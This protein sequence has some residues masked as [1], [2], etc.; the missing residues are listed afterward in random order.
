M[1]TQQQNKGKN[2][3]IFLSSTF[4]DMDAER[5]AIMNSVY[6]A[7]AQQLAPH[8]I[9]VDFIDLRWGVST[10]DVDEAERENHVLRECID[11][12]QSSRPFFIGLL[13][14]R[15]GWVPSQESWDT[16]VDGMTEEEKRF[17]NSDT[18]QARS[19]TELEIL[20][21]SLMDTDNLHRSFFCFRSPEVYAH[22]DAAHLATF[23]EQGDAAARR[24]AQLKEKIAATMHAHRLD[25]NVCRYD[26]R[27]DGQHLTGMDTLAEFLTTA[28]VQEIMLY[29]CEDQT[30]NPDNAYEDM[31]RRDMERVAQ[32]NRLFCGRGDW[33]RWLKEYVATGGGKTLLLTAP[34]GFGKTALVCRLYELLENDGGFTPYIYFA[35]R[36]DGNCRP[37]MP[38]KCWLADPR[39]R[40]DHRCAPDADEDFGLLGHLLAK[41]FATD[42]KRKVLIVDD[43]TLL[44]EFQTLLDG[45]WVPDDTTVV[46]TS[47]SSLADGLTLCD[48][49]R[50]T[51]LSSDDARQLVDRRLAEVGKRLQPGV[52]EALLGKTEGKIHSAT[53]PLWAVMTARRLTLLNASYFDA[54]RQR[55]ESDDELKIQ[56]SLIEIIN[57]SEGYP[58][59][60]FMTIVKEGKQFVDMEFGLD[61]LRLLAVSEFGLRERDLRR[62][63][64]KEW[65]TLKFAELRRYLGSLLSEHEESGVIDFAWPNF[66]PELCIEA[67]GDIGRYLVA[68]AD[69]LRRVA[70]DD[71]LDPVA[72]RELP[73]LALKCQSTELLDLVVM[74]RGLMFHRSTIHALADLAVRRWQF[75]EKWLAKAVERRPAD[76]MR[77][78]PAV[79]ERLSDC[80]NYSSAAAIGSTIIRAVNANV[81]VGGDDT[82]LHRDFGCFTAFF[83]VCLYRAGDRQTAGQWA[84]WLLNEYVG[85]IGDDAYMEVFA[86]AV[87]VAASVW[88]DTGADAHGGD[89]GGDDGGNGDA[90]RQWTAHGLAFMQRLIIDGQRLEFLGAQHELADIFRTM[91]PQ[92]GGGSDTPTLLLFDD[93]L[94]ERPWVYRAYFKAAPLLRLADTMAETD[95]FVAD[96]LRAEAEH[97]MGLVTE[98]A[99]D[100]LL[101]QDP[102]RNGDNGSVG[103]STEEGT[104]ADGAIA[105]GTDETSVR[106]NLRVFQKALATADSRSTDVKR[107]VAN[108]IT[109]YANKVMGAYP[110]TDDSA[111]LRAMD[112]FMWLFISVMTRCGG[113]R[114][115]RLAELASCVF[116]TEYRLFM[117]QGERPSAEQTARLQVAFYMVCS[118]TEYAFRETVNAGADNGDSNL[119]ERVL[120][121]LR[122][123]KSLNLAD[124]LTVQGYALVYH[125]LAY[126]CEQRHDMKGMMFY[127]K[128]HEYATCEAWRLN[129]TDFEA[130]RRHAAAVDETGRMFY[131][132]CGNMKEAKLCFTKANTMF[133]ELYGRRKDGTI[134]NDIVLSSY[135]IINIL[136]SEGR[137]DELCAK[138]E[139][140]LALADGQ[141]GNPELD[142]AIVAAVSES[143]GHALVKLGR[144]GE[145]ERWLDEARDVYTENLRRNPDDEKRM[146]DLAIC[147][148]RQVEHRL[149]KGCNA[150]EALALVDK[151]E[152]L[153]K[154]ALEIVPDSP[155]VARNYIGVLNTKMRIHLFMR[156]F[157][158]TET[159]LTLFEQLTLEHIVATRDTSLMPLMFSCYDTFVD[160][161]AQAGWTQMANALLQVR[162]NAADRLVE[163]RLMKAE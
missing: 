159:A 49:A 163:E 53:T 63:L 97:L 141:C 91:H 13:G 136:N 46:C 161:A 106:A 145:A 41:A 151:A 66:R 6:P 9:T 78:M 19:V 158:N 34:Y 29:E 39:T 79:M 62:L 65:D 118:M 17:I 133:E 21:G 5:D 61:V 43:V 51:L 37:E 80:G 89:D 121:Q 115:G 137:Y 152:L 72:N 76:T 119:S 67:G 64:G 48:R 27:W 101:L 26:C 142:L 138:A 126:L 10:S 30:A 139:Q 55:A 90:I 104:S 111:T 157:K 23:R 107:D 3:K 153:L 54:Q 154:K 83:A 120:G 98:V 114:F 40:S 123:M 103:G 116:N 155:K 60:L 148:M 2:I 105:D 32:S 24:L 86:W 124:T 108:A 122:L 70:A 125:C 81:A 35:D 84:N 44:D 68:L 7:V 33:L 20:F 75:V 22:I 74:S 128:Q 50:L 14:D 71:P 132:V 36:R 144:N 135:N 143:L 162:Q 73:Y 147:I 85:Q 100:N 131:M 117:R 127:N 15:Y 45:S 16:I 59:T 69:Y 42:T 140:T 28:L 77:L 96:T 93:V 129:P 87:Y 88:R 160:T 82:S 150:D 57:Q 58:E 92:D 95:S 4:R 94:R 18:A 130:A 146:R 102:G 8:G 113:M 11:G 134:L 110:D 149:A 56:N 25:R 99:P 52:M 1:T 112:D 31:E 156:D 47:E 12:I 109:G 38:L